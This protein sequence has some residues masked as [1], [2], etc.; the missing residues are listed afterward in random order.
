MFLYCWIHTVS[1]TVNWY[2][3]NTATP[4]VGGVFQ[5]G[6][7]KLCVCEQN[8]GEKGQGGYANIVL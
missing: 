2:V 5:T 3:P 8:R 7:M 1:Y 4:Q 6:S